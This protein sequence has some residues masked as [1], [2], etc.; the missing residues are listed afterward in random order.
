MRRFLLI[1]YFTAL[2]IA[3]RNRRVVVR[4]I[5]KVYPEEVA[6]LII[7]YFNFIIGLRIRE[8]T[9]EEIDNKFCFIRSVFGGL[10]IP[11]ISETIISEMKN[12]SE[13]IANLNIKNKL[14]E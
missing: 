12:L 10:N 3:R 4:F 8:L 11:I 13:Y 2:W 7:I 14:A 1:F 9:K 6:E 5:G